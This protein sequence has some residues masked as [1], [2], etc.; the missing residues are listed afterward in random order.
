MTGR[1]RKADKEKGNKERDEDARQKG[2]RN[3]SDRLKKNWNRQTVLERTAPAGDSVRQKQKTQACLTTVHLP[4]HHQTVSTH[5]KEARNTNKWTEPP[6]KGKTQATE[7]LCIHTLALVHSHTLVYTHSWLEQS[8][9]V[10]WA[11]R[12]SS[13]WFTATTSITSA[14]AQRENTPTQRWLSRYLF[15]CLKTQNVVFFTCTAVFIKVGVC[16]PFTSRGAHFK[17]FVWEFFP[18]KHAVF[19]PW[20][21][22]T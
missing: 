12:D 15:I 9:C 6:V 20:C 2:R 14:T 17:T 22:I 5:R 11:E 19:F 18:F 1:R 7:T 16:L 10:Q 13:V 8:S 3:R 21:K 4:V